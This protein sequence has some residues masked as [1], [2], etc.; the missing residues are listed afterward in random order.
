MVWMM[1]VKCE[2]S[3]NLVKFTSSFSS[4]SELR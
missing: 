2:D 1:Y 4:T 3:D